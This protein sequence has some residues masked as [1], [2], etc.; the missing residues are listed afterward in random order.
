MALQPGAAQVQPSAAPDQAETGRSERRRQAIIK[1]ATEV[2]VQHGYLR[3]TTDEVAILGEAMQRL[4]DRGLLQGLADPDLAAYQ[5]AG[6]VM[7]QPMNQVMFGGTDA[8]PPADQLNRIAD[9]AVDTFLATY[10]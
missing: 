7:Y 10:G 6:L 3:A 8:L 1:A 9:A 4:A 2:F 5:F